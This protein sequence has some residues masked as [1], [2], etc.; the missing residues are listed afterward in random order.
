MTE[1]YQPRR[2]GE[3]DDTSSS[4][5]RDKKILWVRRGHQTNGYG[6]KF[7]CVSYLHANGTIYDD[8]TLDGHL[9]P[10]EIILYLN[11][12]VKKSVFDMPFRLLTFMWFLLLFTLWFKY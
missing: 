2:G 8:I 7:T 9:N 1:G 3:V 6:E 11:A 5:R 10:D 12:N 4:I